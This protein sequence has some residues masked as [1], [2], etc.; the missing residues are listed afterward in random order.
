M[1][2]K[3][4]FQVERIIKHPRYSQTNFDNDI[5]LVKLTEPLKFEGVLN[6]VCLAVPKKSFT[7]DDG[8]VTGWGTLKEG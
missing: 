4:H 6:P 5:A 3:F 2:E 1:T 7:G 8:I